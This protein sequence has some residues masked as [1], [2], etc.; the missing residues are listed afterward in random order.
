MG[1]NKTG[2]SSE[3]YFL[4]K[5]DDVKGNGH[6]IEKNMGSKFCQWQKVLRNTELIYDHPNHHHHILFLDL[7]LL[8]EEELHIQALL[9][10]QTLA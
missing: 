5:Y 9:R 1:W 7:N 3:L 8:S 2:L 4:C 6:K 10:G